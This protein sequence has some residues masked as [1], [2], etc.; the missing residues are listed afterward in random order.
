MV[1]REQIIER[2]MKLYV[3]ALSDAADE[4]G[5]G[6][7]CM[8]S[9]IVPLTKNVRLAGFAR[10]AKL[11]KSPVNQPYDEEQLKIFMSLA[12]DA[13]DGD[14]I[15]ID[16]ASATD[17][18]AWGQVMTKIGLPR[19]LR[20]AV[21]DGTSRDIHDID[22]VNFAVFGIGR[23]PGTMRGRMDMESVGEPIVCGGVTV[24][25]GDL[26]FGDGDGVVVIPQARIEEVLISAEEVVSTDKWWEDKLEDGED[27]YDLHK[28]KP[29]P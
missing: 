27:P 24:S 8:D 7:V 20:G 13:I 25:P 11:V 22:Q 18:S 9:V 28:E 15:V 14:L 19:G 6:R 16:T 12:T 5:I 26:I 1:N 2:T 29:M 3:A 4:V 21:I 10:T 17:C 23:H